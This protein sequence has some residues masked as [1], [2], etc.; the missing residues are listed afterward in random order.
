M[1]QPWVR[2]SVTFYTDP[3]VAKLSPHAELL[4]VRAIAW[5]AAE[6]TDGRIPRAA[7]G[8]LGARLPRH[9]RITREIVDAGLWNHAGDG[10][11]IP[12]KT[13]RR[14]QRTNEQLDRERAASAKRS[15]RYRAKKITRDV[16]RDEPSPSR[17]DGPVTSRVSHGG[18][19]KKDPDTYTEPSYGTGAPGSVVLEDPEPRKI[20]PTAALDS[21]RK[22]WGNERNGSASDH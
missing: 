5:C 21:L 9:A 17:R 6:R 10:W 7:L 20:D 22:G 16:T 2:L 11:R 15:A 8:A 19:N 13:W 18:K 12:L 1:P 4:Y 3:R 14:W